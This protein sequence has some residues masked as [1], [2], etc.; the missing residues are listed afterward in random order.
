ML[1]EPRF[2]KVTAVRACYGIKFKQRVTCARMVKK[3]TK[4]SEIK[5]SIKG[6]SINT[7]LRA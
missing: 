2:M 1:T 4:G 3:G 5:S 6:T 7:R